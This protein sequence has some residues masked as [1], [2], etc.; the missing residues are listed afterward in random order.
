MPVQG[1]IITDAS[2]RIV[3]Q[4]NGNLEEIEVSDLSIGIYVIKARISDS[5]TSKIFVKN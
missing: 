4:A 2:G 3:K 1:V 5:I